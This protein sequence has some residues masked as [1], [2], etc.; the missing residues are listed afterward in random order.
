MSLDY[1]CGIDPGLTG[2]IAF[3]RPSD[4][5][6]HI[7]DMPTTTR[8]IG[9]SKKERIDVAALGN[10]FDDWRSRILGA[11]IE[12]VSASPQ[13]GV[14]S[15][16]N[17]GESAGIAKMAVAANIIPMA[18]VKPAKWKG[19]LRLNSDKNRS[20]EVA[21]QITNR[22]DLFARKKD[23]GRAEAYLLAFYGFKFV[24]F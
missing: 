4:N 9:G 23:D 24:T 1:Y 19:D 6:L 16:F 14:S 10:L 11:V 17:F 22:A 7:F 13:M 18:L 3:W 12:D 8:T 20:R 5:D 21:T 2:A 15:A